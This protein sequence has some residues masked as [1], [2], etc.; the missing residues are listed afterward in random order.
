MS[1]SV[2]T[3][4]CLKCGVVLSHKAPTLGHNPSCYPYVRHHCNNMRDRLQLSPTDC[5]VTLCELHVTLVRIPGIQN[6]APFCSSIN[7]LWQS[8]ENRFCTMTMSHVHDEQRRLYNLHKAGAME[9]YLE[10]VKDCTHKL[11][12]AGSMVEEDKL[13]SLLNAEEMHLHKEQRSDVPITNS[14]L[15]F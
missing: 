11:A 6:D 5:E 10:Y 2:D 14:V 13:V 3:E 12:A 7:Q 15:Q 4:V 1:D 9:A 8:L